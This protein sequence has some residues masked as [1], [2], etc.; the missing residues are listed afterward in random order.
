LGS[1]SN[2]AGGF[3]PATADL[4]LAGRLYFMR[5]AP[6]GAGDVLSPGSIIGTRILADSGIQHFQ[7]LFDDQS[8]DIVLG[9]KVSDALTGPMRRRLVRRRPV[10]VVSRGMRRFRRRLC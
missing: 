8:V 10:C 7:V 9:D 5:Y 3:L 6:L 4:A 2:W 1:E